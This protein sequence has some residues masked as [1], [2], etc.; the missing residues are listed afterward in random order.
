MSNNEQSLAV[1]IKGRQH[2]LPALR[3]GRNVIAV[4]EG[5]VVR[6]ARVHDEVWLGP[7]D[8]PDVPEI[9]DRLNDCPSRVDLFTFVQKLPDTTPRYPYHLEHDYL[10][11]A[12]FE[13]YEDWF[14]KRVDHSV[15]THVRKSRKEGIRTEVVQLTDELVDG[16]VSIYNENP[17]RQGK[18]FWHYGKTASIVKAENSS[19]LDRSIFV[20]AFFEDQLVGFAKLVVDGTVATVMQILC[21]SAYFKKS[22][23]NALVAKAVEVCA[24]RGIRYISY[25]EF[26]HGRND[27]NTLIEFK[28]HNGFERVG[29]PR[30]YVPLS[31]RGRVAL[32]MG[33][34]RGTRRFVPTWVWSLALAARR[35]LT[36]GRTGQR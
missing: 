21:K 31:L 36:S 10:A 1:S 13:S 25:G 2:L 24:A 6:T 30:Y 9:L 20:G 29:V 3:I 33:L 14:E 28:R 7:Q 35:V 16:I 18:K 12:H 34:H 4:V 23:M 8:T 17:V 11:V 5:R 19:Y 27:R 15:R 32:K 26:A 22:P